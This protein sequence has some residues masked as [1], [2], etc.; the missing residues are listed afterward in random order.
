MKKKS[1]LIFLLAAAST[2]SI[3]AATGC[4]EG[5]NSTPAPPVHQEQ[6]HTYGEWYITAPTD[7]ATGVAMR[8]CTELDGGEQSYVLPVLTDPGYTV[9]N[10]TATATEAGTGTY[11]ITIDGV[12]FS[13]TA[14]TPAKG[15][16]EQPK[17]EY[18]VHFN[19]NGHGAA[20]ADAQTVDG[21]VTKPTD[22][23]D[24][25]YDFGGWYTDAA[26]T[27][28]F[29]FN[30]AL[31]AET[32]IYAKWTAKATEPT[33]ATEYTVHFN[34]NGHGLAISDAQTVDGKVARPTDPTDND[35]DFGGWYADAACTISFDFNVVLTAE[36][37]IYAKWTAKQTTPDP[38]PATEYTVHF[39][40]NGHGTAIADAQT[41]DGKVSKPTD[42]TDNDY[43]FGGWYTDADC[44]TAFDFNTVLTAETTIYAK[45]TAKQTTP[46]PTPATEY[47]VHFNLN[48]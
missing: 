2:L 24:N 13:F 35:Y 16:P 20:I 48:G 7:K 25:D 3:T 39:N 14:K 38:T 19:L 33:P 6:D 18:T 41:V 12:T 29:D 21:K 36:T 42:P 27:T 31:T 4:N 47:T 1:L 46:D 44:T 43:D 26:C 9:T 23:T 22:P 15:E 45:W 17:T 5:D 40:L 8:L 37:T 10:D 11:T 34:I 28:A 30:T 32:T